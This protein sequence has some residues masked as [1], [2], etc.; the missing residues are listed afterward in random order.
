VQLSGYAPPKQEYTPSEVQAAVEAIAIATLRI[1]DGKVR[2]IVPN[3][4]LKQLTQ[5]E[6]SRHK[7][8]PYHPIDHHPSKCLAVFALLELSHSARAESGFPDSDD[9][10]DD[11]SDEE[12]GDLESGRG[13]SKHGHHKQ[14][15]GAEEFVAR[16][17]LRSRVFFRS[18][19]LLC[20]HYSLH[21]NDTEY[22]VGGGCSKKHG[23]GAEASS[24][25]SGWS[26]WF[27]GD[28]SKHNAGSG[29][30]SCRLHEL[31]SSVCF[32]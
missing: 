1:R 5:G 12:E 24:S 25:S 27:S 23:D 8:S 26:S 19:A 3:G 2:G 29:I 10:S 6:D 14:S 13:K 18:S 20:S 9:E 30:Q 22:V 16:G 31:R 17:P 11:E 21:Y 28:K 32:L 7:P 4:I 15:S